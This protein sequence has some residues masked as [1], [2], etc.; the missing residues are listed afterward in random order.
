MP[1]S[2][3]SLGRVFAPVSNVNKPEVITSEEA[4]RIA[5]LKEDFAG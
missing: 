2:E 5:E 4:A 3:K 1:P